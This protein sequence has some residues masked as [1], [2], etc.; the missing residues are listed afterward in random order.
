MTAH[1]VCFHKLLNLDDIFNFG[2]MSLKM[3]VLSLGI[4]VCFEGESA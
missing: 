2:N 3:E 1:A 4:S